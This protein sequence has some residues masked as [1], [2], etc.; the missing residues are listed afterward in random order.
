MSRIWTI[1][2]YESFLDVKKFKSILNDGY[3]IIFHIY[4]GKSVLY[5]LKY[6]K[7]FLVRRNL[8]LRVKTAFLQPFIVVKR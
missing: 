1:S 6:T 4:S 8:C 2:T 7:C 3:M 5:I